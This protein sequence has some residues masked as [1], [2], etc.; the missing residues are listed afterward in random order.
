MNRDE[1]S[2]LDAVT[3]A[4][5]VTQLIKGSNQETFERDLRTQ[6]AVLYQI[7]VLG[8]AVKRLSMEY[9][10]QH[11]EIEWRAIAGMR[12]KIMHQYDR[13]DLGLVWQVTQ[14]DLP[15]LLAQLTPLLP[16]PEE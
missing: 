1:A 15:K 7:A 14:E 12:D 8:E 13:V 10:E 3:F 5:N 6:S 2:L 9:R 11:P 16:Q 4:K